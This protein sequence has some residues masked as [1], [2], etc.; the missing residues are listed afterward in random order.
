MSKIKCG[1]HVILIILL[2]A[3]IS[4]NLI[5]CKTTYDKS[6]EN[7]ASG[8]SGIQGENTGNNQDGDAENGETMKIIIKLQV[9]DV[10]VHAELYNN[11]AAEMLYEK[12]PLTL[13]MSD[14][15]HEKYSYL[16]FTLST[17]KENVGKINAGDIMLWGNNCL[18]V[19]YESFETSYSY[20][21]IGRISDIESFLS[22]IDSGSVTLT[23]EKA[24]EL[25]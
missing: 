4:V 18:V 25:M 7:N 11:E 3:L 5:A 20:T 21:K 1:K 8:E 9:E 12:L 6:D 17:N 13:E 16:G 14:M 10:V 24:E 22:A 2:I 15:P 23:F 19:F